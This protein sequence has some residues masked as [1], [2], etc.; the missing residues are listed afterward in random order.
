[1]GM[2]TVGLRTKQGTN[3]KETQLWSKRNGTWSPGS[4]HKKTKSNVLE[5]VML[6]R[7][8]DGTSVV[9]HQGSS[10]PEPFRHSAQHTVSSLWC[11]QE[12]SSPSGRVKAFMNADPRTWHVAG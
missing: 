1:M 8:L 5:G 12:D 10:H 9:P 11:Q 7:H 6:E 3:C 4:L 2:S